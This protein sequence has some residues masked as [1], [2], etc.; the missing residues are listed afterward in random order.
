MTRI[1]GP[2]DAVRESGTPVTPP[3]VVIYRGRSPGSR[4]NAP[5]R[6]PEAGL[7]DIL[8]NRSPLT[9]A[10]AASASGQIPTEFPLSC[11]LASAEPR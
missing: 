3:V 4:L 9:V 10:G 2:L 6:L 11:E 1:R 5:V 7:S 8:D